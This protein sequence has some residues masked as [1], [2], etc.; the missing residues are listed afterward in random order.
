MVDECSR[1]SFP[2]THHPGGY[3]AGMFAT[4]RHLRRADYAEPRFF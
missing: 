4:V 3:S 2:T 1:E